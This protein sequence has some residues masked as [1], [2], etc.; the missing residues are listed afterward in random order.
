MGKYDHPWHKER[1]FWNL[2]S[3]MYFQVKL[4]AVWSKSNLWKELLQ[5]KMVS[6]GA[7]LGVGGI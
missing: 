5:H 1:V 2:M 3:H 4:E 7:C 6:D